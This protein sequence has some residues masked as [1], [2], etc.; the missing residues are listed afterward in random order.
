MIKGFNKFIYRIPHYSL[1]EIT[2][3]Q[4][5]EDIHVYLKHFFDKSEFQQALFTASPEFYA[6]VEL[7]MKGIM[8][9]GKRLNKFYNT[10]LKYIVRMGSRSTPFGLF[11]ACG[12]GEINSN[13]VITP[14]S[15]LGFKPKVRLDMG[16]LTS[17]S[18]YILGSQKLRR[19]L[20]FYSNNTVYE[21][22]NKFRYVEFTIKAGEKL[23]NLSSFD[24]NL[25][26]ISILEV[27]KVGLEYSQFVEH[28]VHQDISIEE[29]EEF[30]D[31]LI[32]SRILL[33]E[34][35]PHMT[36]IEYSDQIYKFIERQNSQKY[37]D[38]EISKFYNKSYHILSS[39]H[40]RTYS[41]YN[42]TQK[43]NVDVYKDVI[44]LAQQLDTKYEVKHHIQIDSSCFSIENGATLS[45]ELYK[46][47]IDGVTLVSRF[48][49]H[50]SSGTYLEFK[51]KFT[52]KY[53]DRFIKLSEAL[54]PEGGLGYGNTNNDMLDIT[55]FIDDLPVGT[56]EM[57][58]RKVIPWDTKKHN[59]IL[60][61]IIEA[62]KNAKLSIEFTTSEIESL[63]PKVNLLPPT[64][65]A[66]VSISYEDE[67]KPMIYFHQ[68][69]SSS[70]TCLIGRF[71]FL[72]SK[73]NSLIQDISQSESDYYSGKIV[74]EINH[75][76]ESRAGNVMLRP[77]NRSH[78]ICYLTKSNICE[79]GKIEISDLYLTIRNGKFILFSKALNKEIVPRLSNAHNFHKDTLPVY[80]FLCDLQEDESDGYLGLVTDLGA[81]SDLVN[82]I[83]RLTYKNYII[84][85]AHW[86]I[87]TELIRRFIDLPDAEFKSAMSD[88]FKAKNIPEWFL[89]TNR[90][91]DYFVNINDIF[92]LRAFFD[93]IKD[94]SR[95]AVKE[96]LNKPNSKFLVAN[97][98]GNYLHELIVPLHR[99][100]NQKEITHTIEKF[101]SS[102][103]IDK[104]EVIKRKFYPGDTWVYFKIYVGVKT[105]EKIIVDHFATLI[106]TLRSKRLISR[107][108]FIRY[109]DPDFHI[110]LRF[111][112]EDSNE[113]GTVV[114]CFQDYFKDY[115][116]SGRIKKLMLD[117]YERELERY[118]LDSM[119]YAEK[120]F[121]IDSELCISLLGLINE[122]GVNE[123]KWLFAL[124]IMDAYFNGFN[125]SEEKKLSFSKKI[126]DLFASEFSAN[127]MQRRYFI[128][129]YRNNKSVIDGFIDG[130]KF[131][132]QDI[133]WFNQVK[134]SFQLQIE[135]VYNTYY[136]HIS[137]EQ[138]DGYLHSFIHM[139][140]DRFF[141]S[142]NRHHEYALYSLIEQ[143]YRYRIGKL[144]HVSYED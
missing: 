113:Y 68:V 133:V 37:S 27:G 58:T 38:S 61:K 140:I 50:G 143:F 120:L 91:N 139:F 45:E 115:L 111:K 134:E 118:G 57:N 122:Y 137:I 72:D 33:S 80:K 104:S 31:E 15:A 52:E 44:Y 17:F 100:K 141:S 9:T 3:M 53:G 36:G 88:F 107:W 83:P 19:T 46:Q 106:G 30:I 125:F 47:I 4:T 99:E 1:N 70:A 117:T 14:D 76:S 55:P 124:G 20:K 25:Y 74:A 11:S 2:E 79:E 54:D 114:N 21:F 86:Y 96:S 87:E 92:S 32:D 123:Y 85:P 136:K 131:D 77:K 73:I 108:F 132:N 94:S 110:R 59:L 71:G 60:K 40:E 65:N 41:I 64:F 138:S 102:V 63:T 51:R 49:T 119:D 7:F 69:G 5:V 22:G 82:F 95:F 26:I 43:V 128:T 105:G 6:E 109:T 28:L 8:P 39:I 89:L 42:N 127:K 18:E 75:L 135:N 112:L 101:D 29:A 66:F 35:E 56:K 93:E 81:I 78:E 12:V 62:E 90:E 34:L 84:W 48:A 10:A 126:R 121:D 67:N 97:Q 142:K 98:N 16:L 24:K 130:G 129:K 23:Y 103:L 116:E 144:Q 13:N